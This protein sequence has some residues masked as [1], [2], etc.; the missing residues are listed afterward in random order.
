[1]NFRTSNIRIYLKYE[2][3]RNCFSGFNRCLR[4]GGLKPGLALSA[5]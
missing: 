5:H 1:V 3:F 2:K 4:K